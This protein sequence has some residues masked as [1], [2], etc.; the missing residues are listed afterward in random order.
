[1]G[2]RCYAIVRQEEGA[3]PVRHFVG[4]PPELA[5]GKP[6]PVPF[7]RPD[8]LIITADPQG[9][10]MLDRYTADGAVAGDTWHETG[11][12]AMDQAQLEYA[13]AVGEWREVPEGVE[14]AAAFALSRFREQQGTGP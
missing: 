2:K 1:M 4:L 10:V 14:D 7:P 5:A 13:D 9:G 3:P 6:G 12:Y 11:Q 8:V